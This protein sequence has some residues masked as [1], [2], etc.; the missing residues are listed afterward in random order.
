MAILDELT[1]VIEARKSQRPANSY[2]V[3]LL[4][5]GLSRLSAKIEEEAREVVAAAKPSPD[6]HSQLTHEAADLVFHLLV[7]LAWADI[8]WT[9]VE[10]ELAR[11]FGVGGLEEKAQRRN[12]QS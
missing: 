8:P 4:D 10:S 3:Q 2:V 6:R 1:A 12:P 11:R 5:G 9:A 7:L